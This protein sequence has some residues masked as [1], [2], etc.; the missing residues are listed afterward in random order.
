MMLY[1]IPMQFCY[2]AIPVGNDMDSLINTAYR[3]S[4]VPVVD[5][6]QAFI[7]LVKRSDIIH[8]IYQGYSQLKKAGSKPALI[9]Q[10]RATAEK[11]YT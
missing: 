5:D 7:G 9:S 1:D 8:Y 6:T 4:F 11:L 3:Q 10:R 2:E